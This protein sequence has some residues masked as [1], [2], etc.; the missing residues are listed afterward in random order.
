MNIDQTET[1]GGIC[2]HLRPN[3]ES[4]YAYLDA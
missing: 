4:L 2:M 3:V 1:I